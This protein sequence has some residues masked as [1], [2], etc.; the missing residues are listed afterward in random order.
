MFWKKTEIKYDVLIPPLSKRIEDLTPK[1]TKIFFEWYIGQI[2]KRVEYLASYVA[3]QLN[4]DSHQIDYSPESLIL[5]WKWFLG[6]AQTERTPKERIEGLCNLYV[7]LP[8]TLRDYILNE[9]R[10]QFSLQTEYI[11]RDIGMYLGEVFVKNSQ[12]IHWGYYTKPKTDF[13]VNTPLLLGFEDNRFE[14]PFKMTFEPIHMVGVQAAN[15]WDKTQKN[16]DLF[17]LYQKWLSWIPLR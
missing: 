8:I 3:G 14:P 9:S 6:I 15:I 13:Y 5:V 4:I 7:D 16:T 1:E 10:E 12:C 2:P 17:E 11:L